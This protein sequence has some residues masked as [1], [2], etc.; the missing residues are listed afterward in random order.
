MKQATKKRIEKLERAV[1]ARRE[2]IR[3][4]AA[5]GELIKRRRE[6]GISQQ[7]MGRLAG[8]SAITIINFEKGRPLRPLTKAAIDRAYNHIESYKSIGGRSFRGEVDA[9]WLKRMTESFLRQ[10][11]SGVV[12]TREKLAHFVVSSDRV[13]E[14]GRTILLAVGKNID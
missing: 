12:E 4:T 8:V 11:S 13:Y 1:S 9:A 6:A 10:N 3:E 5:R 2:T 14:F 7:S